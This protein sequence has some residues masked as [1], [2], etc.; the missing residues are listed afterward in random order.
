MVSRR[1]RR[2][3]MRQ[4]MGARK[5]VHAKHFR[6]GID[7]LV[8]SA[9]FCEPSEQG[10]CPALRASVAGPPS[11]RDGEITRQTSLTAAAA[12]C[13]DAMQRSAGE[14]SDSSNLAKP[15]CASWSHAQVHKCLSHTRI[16]RRTCLAWES[17]GAGASQRQH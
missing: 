9:G 14:K 2:Y 13:G 5:R 8:I 11:P 16:L 15:N 6:G 1:V 10:S 12:S 17:I 7:T 3:A 4:Q